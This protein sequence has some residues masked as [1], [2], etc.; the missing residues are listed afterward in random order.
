M[1]RLLSQINHLLETGHT[2]IAVERDV[3]VVVGL[4]I[5]GWGEGDDE[6]H[7]GGSKLKAWLR[8]G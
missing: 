7:C 3:H 5:S 2:V 8:A 1:D 4:V 6:S